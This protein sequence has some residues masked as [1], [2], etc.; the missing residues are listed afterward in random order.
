[1]AAAVLNADVIPGVVVMS[2]GAW[3]DP[4]G[5]SLER[6]G[7]PNVLTVDIGTSPLTQAPSALSALVQVAKWEGEVP[8][9]KAFELPRISRDV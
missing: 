2:T 9:V 5:S 3:F 8:D 1:M 6:H 7:N 4:Q